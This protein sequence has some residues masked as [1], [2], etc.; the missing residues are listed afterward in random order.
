MLTTKKV[1]ICLVEDGIRI[2]N[3]LNK[4]FGYSD[5]VIPFGTLVS[6]YN[7]F[8]WKDEWGYWRQMKFSK[9][10]GWALLLSGG[11]ATTQWSLT[12]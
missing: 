6:A 12:Y 10:P 3:P 9:V 1:E 7:S 2:S 8:F 5:I 11:R 4:G